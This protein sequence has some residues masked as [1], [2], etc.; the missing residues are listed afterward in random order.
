MKTLEAFLDTLTSISVQGD[1][2]R[3]LSMAREH[4][5]GDP[6]RY[7]LGASAVYAAAKRVEPCMEHAR[8]AY[9][10]A[11][12]AALVLQQYALAH[13][14]AHRVE[15]A[16]DY[17]RQA[18]ACDDSV[19][20]RRGLANILLHAGKL[21]EA[22][23]LFSGILATDPGNVQARNG[24]GQVHWHRGENAAA[25]E[26]FADA[27]AAAPED[28]HALRHV[29]DM[30]VEAGWAIGAVALS[31]ITRSRQHSDAVNITLDMMNLMIMRQIAP[32]FPGKGLIAETAQTITGLVD[33]STSLSSAVQLH[34]ARMLFDSKH[35]DATRTI[36]DRLRGQTGT[37][38]AADRA[39]WHYVTGLLAEE[40]SQPD[41][42]LAHYTAAVEADGQRWDACCNAVT[43][44]LQRGGEAAL[45]EA[46]R[47]LGL[48]PGELKLFR[49]Q[50]LYNEAVFL[51]R[52]GR[53]D[54]AARHCR[55]IVE[56]TAGRGPMAELARHTLRELEAT[57]A[58]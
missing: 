49:H 29:I 45:A 13:V 43:I 19:R 5:H 11:P 58:N 24:L 22:E 54:E 26:H 23:Q 35:L 39:D 10:Q 40:A 32:D 9:E 20:S 33:C 12:Q 8:Q 15:L 28:P 53:S 36:V 25:L 27:Y 47:L 56:M 51:R 42:A 38:S 48:V 1:I 30:Y 18:V 14:L 17:A 2:Y 21:D 52:A 37:L 46:G 4:E 41:E 44:L 34:I 6:L 57:P 3:A 7:H 31:R 16:E 55:T 50:L